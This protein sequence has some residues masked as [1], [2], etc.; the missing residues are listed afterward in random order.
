MGF[1]GNVR[2]KVKAAFWAA[3]A[4]VVVNVAN[5]ITVEYSGVWVALVTAFAPVVAGYMRR[6]SEEV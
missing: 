3:M 1:W 5:A 2:P 6:E 4:M